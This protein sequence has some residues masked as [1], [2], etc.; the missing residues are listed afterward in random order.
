LTS[1]V[2][3]GIIPV[4]S[5]TLTLELPMSATAPGTILGHVDAIRA[6]HRRLTGLELDY[7]EAIRR[8]DAFIAMQ[9]EN[10][11]CPPKLFEVQVGCFLVSEHY[12]PEA[13]RRVISHV[14]IFGT[15]A[16]SPDLDADDA[17][18]VDAILPVRRYGVHAV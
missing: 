1:W 17:E 8:L 15:A 7:R 6:S 3:L 9:N 16:G 11:F 2:S 5:P 14:A 4:L 13:I 18:A 12:T 10:D